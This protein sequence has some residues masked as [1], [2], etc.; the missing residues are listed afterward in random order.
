MLLDQ[1][2]QYSNYSLIVYTDGS[3]NPNPGVIGASSNGYAYNREG[4]TEYVMHDHLFTNVGYIKEDEYDGTQKLVFPSYIFEMRNS[5]SYQFTNNYAEVYALYSLLKHLVENEYFFGSIL[6]YSDSTYLVSCIMERLDEWKVNGWKKADGKPVAEQEL[7]YS[8]AEALDTLKSHGSSIKVEWLKGHNGNLGNE[9]ANFGA[10]VA[11]MDS[12]RNQYENFFQSVKGEV[13]FQTKVNIH[14]L[15]CYNNIILNLAKD[16]NPDNPIYCQYNTDLPDNLVGKVSRLSS[17]SVVA[18]NNGADNVALNNIRK[19]LQR[20]KSYD[21]INFIKMDKLRNKKYYPRILHFPYTSLVTKK[22]SNTLTFLDNEIISPEIN[23]PGLLLNALETY[24]VLLDILSPNLHYKNKADA[25]IDITDYF[26]DLGED[27]KGNIK[28]TLK[29]DFSVGQRNILLNLLIPVLEKKVS[30]PIALGLDLPERNILKR[31]E[32]Y[33]PVIE[34]LI[35]FTSNQSF[36]YYFLIK[37]KDAISIWSNKA[38]S[39]VIFSG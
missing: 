37:T 33:T 21:S 18:F 26:Y 31:L 9:L 5:F 36:E 2:E 23:P 11:R 39:K 34:F 22:M 10:N 29:S 13:F 8:I 4:S 6:V 15:L 24:D 12:H 17:Y 32:E 30:I 27:K 38:S 3:A 16:T 35:C 14:P 1:G 20:M 7:W 19:V 25:V 28:H